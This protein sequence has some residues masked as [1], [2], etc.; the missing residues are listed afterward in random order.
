MK[1]ISIVIAVTAALLVPTLA[2][3]DLK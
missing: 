2:H 1:G 3:A